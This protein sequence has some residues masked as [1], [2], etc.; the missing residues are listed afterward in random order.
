MVPSHSTAGPSARADLA[1]LTQSASEQGRRWGRRKTWEDLKE[2]PG[3]LPAS[4]DGP[5]P[6]HVSG[7]GLGG[8][9]LA[10]ALLKGRAASSRVI[11]HSQ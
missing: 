10:Q 9:V 5:S 2:A 7:G 8:D 3:K 1:W 6:T 4:Q 11:K